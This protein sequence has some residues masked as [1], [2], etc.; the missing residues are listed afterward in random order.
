MSGLIGVS[1]ALHVFDPQHL[2]S[3]VFGINSTN[4]NIIQVV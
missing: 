1:V 2:V 4:N 3:C